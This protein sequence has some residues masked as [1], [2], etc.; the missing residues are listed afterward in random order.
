MAIKR[1]LAPGLLVGMLSGEKAQFLVEAATPRPCQA[2]GGDPQG[3]LP[4][5]PDKRKETQNP[6]SLSLF[7]SLQWLN[8]QS[9]G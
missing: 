7:P 2:A 1:L 4:C 9:G 6:L 8:S 3:Q 5:F